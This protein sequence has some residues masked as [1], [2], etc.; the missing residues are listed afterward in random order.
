MSRDESDIRWANVNW[1]DVKFADFS[2]VRY[3]QQEDSEEE[4][5]VDDTSKFA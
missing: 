2:N 1:S 5:D 3:F 4:E